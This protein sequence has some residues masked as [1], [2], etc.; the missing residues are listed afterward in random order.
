MKSKKIDNAA[1]R[2]QQRMVRRW[3]IACILTGG[4]PIVMYP[5]AVTVKDAK[6]QVKRE[7]GTALKRI[8]KARESA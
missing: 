1:T 3:E 8:T 2:S 7:L 5:S 4:H 6:E